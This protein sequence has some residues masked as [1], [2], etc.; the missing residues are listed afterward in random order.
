MSTKIFPT[1]VEDLTN[2][3]LTEVLH[4]NNISREVSVTGFSIGPVSA[5]G[6]T[7][8]VVRI[9]LEYNQQSPDAPSSLI[10]KFPATFEPARQM[11]VSL[12]TYVRL[13]FSNSSPQALK[14]WLPIAMPPR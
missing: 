4:K 9:E 1:R 8:N 11:A 12:D 13:I 14:R 6:Q 5:P 10:G 7:S 2:N 3:W